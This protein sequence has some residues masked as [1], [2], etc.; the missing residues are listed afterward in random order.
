MAARALPRA[1]GGAGGAGAGGR[2]AASEACLAVVQWR[3]V[4]GLEEATEGGQGEWR[5]FDLFIWLTQDVP[6]LTQFVTLGLAYPAHPGR[7]P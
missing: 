7:Y 3:P 4:A 5:L 6:Q 2:R 1:A